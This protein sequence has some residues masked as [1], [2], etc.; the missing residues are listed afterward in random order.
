LQLFG[1]MDNGSMDKESLDGGEGGM[2]LDAGVA[3]HTGQHNSQKCAIFI[4]A[5]MYIVGF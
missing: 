4:I 1:E 2:A 3:R 5:T